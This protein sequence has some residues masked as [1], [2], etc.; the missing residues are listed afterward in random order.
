MI[1]SIFLFLILFSVSGMSLSG[2]N[3]LQKPDGTWWLISENGSER[4]LDLKNKEDLDMMIKQANHLQNEEQLRLSGQISQEIK[5]TENKI[6]TTVSMLEKIRIQKNYLKQSLKTE[7]NELSKADIT[8][9]KNDIEKNDA[10]ENELNKKLKVFTEELRVLKVIQQ[11]SAKDQARE[12]QKFC[13]KRSTNT[14]QKEIV[15]KQEPAE[16]KPDKSVNKTSPAKRKKAAS[17]FT[18]YDEKKDVYLHPLDKPCSIEFSGIDEFTGKT[19]K[20]HIA[21]PLFFYTP[22]SMVKN[23]PDKEYMTCDASL[24][25]VS[26]GSVFLNLYINIANKEAAK[27]FGGLEK[28]TVINIKFIDGDNFAIINNRNDPGIY[29]PVKQAVAFRAQCN[30][31]A[32]VQEKIS[33]KSLDKIRITWQTGYEDYEVFDVDLLLRQ[34]KCLL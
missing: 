17:E 11:T 16:S 2:Q 15:I 9:L 28:G 18:L 34:Y 10:T 12:Y 1:R 7:K 14:E 23:F 8:R 21:Q 33:K 20:D 32:G 3:V 26:G 30:L 4:M 31:G 5:E 27:L 13:Q 19:R 24:S 22:P 6:Q 25:S 29:D